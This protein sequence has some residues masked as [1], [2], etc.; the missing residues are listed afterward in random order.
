LRDSHPGQRHDH[1]D[2]PHRCGQLPKSRPQ[3]AQN[4][5]QPVL[6]LSG[7]SNVPPPSVLIGAQ[8]PHC[9]SMTTTIRFFY[10]FRIQSDPICPV[11]GGVLQRLRM[12]GDLVGLLLEGFEGFRGSSRRDTDSSLSTGGTNCISWTDSRVTTVQKERIKC[13]EKLHVPVNAFLAATMLDKGV[14]GKWKATGSFIS[15]LMA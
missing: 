9:A 13:G 10:L 3:I 5:L 14:F 7:P 6:A 2:V 11:N 15:L 1:H 4:R 12:P 8:P